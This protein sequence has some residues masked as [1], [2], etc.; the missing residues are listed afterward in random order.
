MRSIGGF[1]LAAVTFAGMEACSDATDETPTAE[2]Q[3]A[4]VKTTWFVADRDTVIID[5]AS[6]FGTV[7]TCGASAGV[8]GGAAPRSCLMHW[9]VPQANITVTAAWLD[10]RVTDAA[11]QLTYLY[12]LRKA[13]SETSATW[14]SATST[15]LW[16]QPGAQG[17]DDRWPAIVTQAFG[18]TGDAVVTLDASG[19]GLSRVQ[20]WFDNPSANN[21][22]ILFDHDFADRVQFATR[23]NSTPAFRPTLYVSYFENNGGEGDDDSAG[24]T[25]TG[26]GGSTG[27]GGFGG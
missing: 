11:S 12:P 3:F 27:T 8:P 22:G 15:T 23:E 1:V 10:L 17:P 18:L 2:A 25:G 24:G 13:W 7:A 5:P 21:H 9:P 26:T 20:S 6:G 14:I 4:N 19:G 16:Q